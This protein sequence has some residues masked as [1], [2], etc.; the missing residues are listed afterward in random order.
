LSCIEKKE[1]RTAHI[2]QPGY[3]DAKPHY[4]RSLAMMMV[5]TIS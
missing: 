3:K 2:G 5:L 4:L 1:N